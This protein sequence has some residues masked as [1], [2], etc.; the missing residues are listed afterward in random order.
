[1]STSVDAK[2]LMEMTP[3][4]QGVFYDFFKKHVPAWLLSAD[5]K[6]R[7]ALYLAL[8][9][10]FKSRSEAMVSL[11]RLQTP[12]AFCTPLLEKALFDKLGTQVDV[13]G[14]IF[15]HVRSTESLLGLRKKLV[16]P[17]N[18]DLLTA[19][20]ENFDESEELASEYH[21]RSL[22]YVPE[23]VNGKDNQILDLQPNEFAT[24]CRSLDLGKRYRQHIET[25]FLPASVTSDARNKWMA[26]ALDNL[27]VDTQLAYMCGHISASVYAM[28]ELLRKDQKSIKLGSNSLGLQKIKM[29]EVLFHGVVFIGP[30]R[31]H[32]DN[33]YRC[34]VYVPGDPL[35]PLKEYSNFDY[36]Q[37]ELSRRLR[38]ADFKKFFLRFIALE[39]RADFE[40]HLQILH[41]RPNLVYVPLEGDDIDG[42][43]FLE[44]YRQ[45]RAHLLADA[46]LL[47]VPTADK[48]ESARIARM[49]RYKAIGINTIMLLLSFVPVMREVMLA[50]SA[51]QLLME[52]YDGI[53]AWGR[54]EQEQATDYLFDTVENL[55]LSATLAAGGAALGKAFKTIRGTSF[56]QQLR[57]VQLPSKAM[58]L[59]KPDLRVYRQPR[60]L[61]SDLVPDER[62]LIMESDKQYLPIGDDLYAVEHVPGLD[63]WQLQHP[64][65][66]ARYQPELETNGA[67]AWRHDSELPAEWNLLTLMRR[68]GIAAHEV[69]DAHIDRL[70]AVS[71]LS[72][73][74]LRQMYVDNRRPA[75]LLMDVV[76]RFKVDKAVTDFIRQMKTRTAIPLADADLQLHLMTSLSDWPQGTAISITN[77]VGRE[78]QRYGAVDATT[79]IPLTQT[80]LRKG[81]FLAPVLSALTAQQRNALLRTASP[82]SQ[83]RA[84]ALAG[85]IAALAGEWQQKLFLRIYQ[86]TSGVTNAE[87][88]PLLQQ[89]PALPAGI[90]EEMTRDADIT[91]WRQLERF[92]VPLRLAEQAQRYLRILRINR[93]YEGLYLDAVSSADTNRLVLDALSHLPGWP[94]NHFVQ[95]MD[96]V[97]KGYETWSIGSANASDKTLIDVFPDYLQARDGEAN[98]LAD[99]PQHTR[100]LYFQTLWEGLPESCRVALGITVQDDGVT[101]RDKVIAVARDRR[102]AFSRLLEPDAGLPDD[103]MGGALAPQVLPPA[104]AAPVAIGN[105][106]LIHRARQLYPMHTPGQID[107]FLVTLGSNDVLRTRKLEAMR[108]E[109]TKMH[110]DLSGWVS[111]DTRYSPARGSRLTVPRHSKMRAAREII[112]AWRKETTTVFTDLGLTYVL[113][114]PAELLGDLPVIVADFSHVTNLQMSKVGASAGLTTFLQNFK[115][116]R[117]LNLS[118]NELTRLPLAI[119]AMTGLQQLDLSDNQI[120]LT[121]DAVSRLSGMTE[122]RELNLSF[123]PHLARAPDVSRMN[124]LEHLALRNTGISDWPAGAWSL[125]RLMTVDARDNAIEQ[126]PSALFASPVALHHGVNVYGN[127]LSAASLHSVAEYQHARNVSL[128]II[129]SNYGQLITAVLSPAAQRA[130]WLSGLP[131]LEATVKQTIWDL[132]A[133]EPNSRDFF[134]VLTH[135]RVSADYSAGFSN[136]RSRVWNI[137][138]AAAENEN[139]RRSQF[140]LARV[141]RVT[142]R[143]YLLLFSALEVQTQYFRAIMAA[144]TGARTLEG[145]LVY[146]LRGLFRLQEV[147]RQVRI[148]L[149]SR[150]RTTVLTQQQGHELSL[151]YRVGLAERLDL[152]AQPTRL[153]SRLSVEVTTVQLDHAYRKV[154][155]A[156]R[157]DALTRY[158]RGQG[159]WNDYLRS[160]YADRFIDTDQR[161]VDGMASLQAQVDLT[162]AV[163][164]QRMRTLFENFRNERQAL[165]NELTEEALGR[166]PGLDL[167][168]VD[169]VAVA[170]KPDG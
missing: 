156:E 69:P 72:E 101:L 49:E 11:G 21:P 145:E 26:Y 46:R 68:F 140:N 159:L 98:I 73:S 76:L 65:S 138:Q 44:L 6:V 95:I 60:R 71:G 107:R 109:Y 42:G 18:R 111:R 19:A 134:L 137:V 63:R 9:K 25:L 38:T 143:D 77:I 20:C 91:E 170:E 2:P 64:S 80:S 124:K 54:G 163:F 104:I 22:I 58:R 136:L 114:L 126:I 84:Q 146:L 135:M 97:G 33:D 90:A 53:E 1:M 120:R 121:A 149:A 70:L 81:E 75:A 167:P 32:A 89:F 61:A 130:L 150:S 34:V 57:K 122:L 106:A 79:I 43:L 35:H 161:F 112:R 31:E 27:A 155:E 158:I 7:D 8:I 132:L 96:W 47:I 5:V 131:L 24:I 29:N 127:P 166:N 45:R 37:S 10:S 139:L 102:A 52:V 66:S 56:L 4:Q 30:V 141:G 123:N 36:F 78:S 83:I 82:D 15:Q 153:D 3:E 169:P 67:G 116:L 51:A 108:L 40:E 165:F 142:G 41:R 39:D 99:H 160:T 93:A 144:R 50:V 105:P 129:S 28:L 154:I 100:A 118:S 113:S 17:I 12:E 103:A 62:G 23:R 128:G 74:N 86:R 157:T 14:V 55:I 162:G 115:N 119:D 13:A 148:D 110:N 164:S 152:P 59:W 117:T 133:E 88:A 94:A 168:P 125:G 151:A 92:T 85:R 48:D 147:E 87:S 16:L